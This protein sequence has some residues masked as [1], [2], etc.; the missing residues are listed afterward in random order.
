PRGIIQ[1]AILRRQLIEEGHS[2]VIQRR[3]DLVQRRIRSAHQRREDLGEG[4]VSKGSWPDAFDDALDILAPVNEDADQL[5]LGRRGRLC[6]S[7]GR[8]SLVSSRLN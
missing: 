6:A 2:I 7:L 4:L 5:S 3:R 8:S 1:S